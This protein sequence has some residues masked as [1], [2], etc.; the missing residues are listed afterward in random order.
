[1]L[2]VKT[3]Q[4]LVQLLLRSRKNCIEALSFEDIVYDIE[5]IVY[6]IEIYA[7]DIVHEEDIVYDIEIYAHDIV[8]DIAYDMGFDTHC[9]QVELGFLS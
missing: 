3:N 8:H 7:H 2:A 6:D 9:I 5:D 4:K 1:M